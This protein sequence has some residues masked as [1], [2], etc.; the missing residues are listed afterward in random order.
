MDLVALGWN[1]RWEALAADGPP[2]TLPG[3]VVRHDGS[4]VLVAS[5]TGVDSVPLRPN[6][7]PVAVG[8]WVLVAGQYLADVLPRSSLLQRRDPTRGGAQVMAANVD[9]VGIVCG[10]DRRVNAGRIQR[11]VVQVWDSDATPIIVLTKAD[12]LANTRDAEEIAAG[13]AGGA[14][15]F[16]VSVTED[17]GLDEIRAAVAD[18]TVAFIGESGAGKSTLVNALAGREIALTGAVREHDAKGRHTTTARELHVLAGN[19]RLID[20]PGM[21]EMGLWTDVETVDEVFDDIVELSELCKFRDCTHDNE[22]GCAVR[23]AVED[24]RLPL[25]HLESWQSLRKEAAGAELRAD[26]YARHQAERRFGK[27]T[28]EAQRLKRPID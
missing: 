6:L 8:D 27:I 20:T 7:P 10:V 4:A 14:E 17:R 1:D 19:V 12:L 21:R 11:M 25:D 13:V 22:P 15:V 9:V 2:D 28:R 16:V 5:A 3:R 26:P 18:R 23:A 24:G